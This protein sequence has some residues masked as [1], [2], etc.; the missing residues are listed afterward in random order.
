ML[1]DYQ[2]GGMVLD[3]LITFPDWTYGAIVAE[4]T[5]NSTGGSTII[6]G[7]RTPTLYL[8]GGRAQQYPPYAES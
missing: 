6:I 7:Q 1:L 2:Q 3:G 8:T 5:A 4:E